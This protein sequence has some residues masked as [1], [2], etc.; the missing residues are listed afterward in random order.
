MEY[1]IQCIGFRVSNQT[2]SPKTIERSLGILKSDSFYIHDS[3][4]FRMFQDRIPTDYRLWQVEE[5]LQN[6]MENR[7]FY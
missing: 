2:S 5:L 1:N 4:I 3:P 6:E 7:E